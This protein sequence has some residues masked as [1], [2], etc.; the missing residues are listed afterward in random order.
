[1]ASFGLKSGIMVSFNLQDSS[2]TQIVH[3]SDSWEKLQSWLKGS[4]ITMLI[5]RSY[6]MHEVT[7]ARL[8]RLEIVENT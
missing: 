3:I 6:I 7:Y 1:M 5:A 4:R 8:L 2:R